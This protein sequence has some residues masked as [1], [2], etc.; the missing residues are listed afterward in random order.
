[1]KLLRSSW[2]VAV[3]GAVTF[4]VTMVVTFKQMPSPA[5]VPVEGEVE[6][7]GLVEVTGKMGEGEVRLMQ[8]EL[9]QMGRDM[10]DKEKALAEWEARLKVEAVELARMRE[11]MR[12]IM[13]EFDE[14]L[15]RV[16]GEEVANLKKS[17]K[18]YSSMAPQKAAEVLSK[19]SNDE[20]IKVLVYM[21]DDEIARILEVMAQGGEAGL[22]R[23]AE[24]MEKLRLSGH[25]LADKN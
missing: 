11:E 12:Q 5:S 14:V 6:A 15:P 23:V 1:M 16:K 20:V 22:Q 2:M 18:V 10:G 8:Q 9:E 24:I 7:G 4:L 3:L 21:K 19:Q 13:A 17:A 25:Q